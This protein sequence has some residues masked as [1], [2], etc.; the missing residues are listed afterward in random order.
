MTI[1]SSQQL[2]FISFIS[3]FILLWFYFSLFSSF[4]FL[5]LG[6]R[7]QMCPIEN[8]FLKFYSLF[9]WFASSFSADSGIFSHLFCFFVSLG[10]LLFVCL[11]IGWWCLFTYPCQKRDLFSH[12]SCWWL[13]MC[14]AY[15]VHS[16][17]GSNPLLKD[18]LNAAPK[19]TCWCMASLLQ[20]GSASQ[21]RT[22]HSHNLM[23]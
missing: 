18:S 21:D 17:T 13:D 1:S 12:G 2:F 11:F 14:I 3:L 6:Y 5:P 15:W 19:T 9:Q 16:H 4:G 8:K 20:G 10:V 23:F 22:F 7:G